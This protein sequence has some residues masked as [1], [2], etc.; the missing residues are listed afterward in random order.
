[1]NQ[2]ATNSERDDGAQRALRRFRRLQ[3]LQLI[4]LT[5]VA[6]LVVAA[7]AVSGRSIIAANVD[8]RE[9]L[10][11]Q[12][13][14]VAQ[15]DNLRGVENAFWRH[16]AS[17][18]PGIPLSI[19]SAMATARDEAKAL[20]ALERDAG[21][22]PGEAAAQAM[23]DGI[24]RSGSLI[25]DYPVYG[26]AVERKLLAQATALMGNVTSITEAW[27]AIHDEQVAKTAVHENDATRALLVRVAL[28]IS[29]LGLVTLFT[30]ILTSRARVGVLD[31]L[32]SSTREQAA[33]RR[34]ATVVASEPASSAVF[35]ALARE[36]AILLGTDLGRVMRFDEA[37]AAVAGVWTRASQGSVFTAHLPE[38]WSISHGLAGRV[39]ASQ[40]CARVEWAQL[41]DPVARTFAAGGFVESI[42][43]P[44]WV[45]S[46]LWGLV[47]VDTTTPGILGAGTEDRLAQFAYLAGLAIA[48]TEARERLSAQAATDPLT[49]LANHGAFHQRLE[50]EV[51]RAQRNGRELSLVLIDLDHFKDINDT[52]G[53]QVGDRVLADI[54][55]ALSPLVREGELLARVGGEELAWL[56]PES[57]HLGAHAAAERARAA[58]S[59]ARP[60]DLD[61]VTASAGVCSLDRAGSSRE[62]YRLADAALFW[63]KSQGRDCAI[64]YEQDAVDDIPHH[65]R[66][67]QMERART[68]GAL[69][70]LARAVDA[71]DPATQRHSE[72]VATMTYD[73]AIE[74]GWSVERAGSLREAALVHDV[75][76][77]GVPDA[78]L[79]K[80]GR[81]DPAEY[82]QIQAHSALGAQIVS[83]VLTP[84]QVGWV[85]HHHERFDAGG[86]PDRL[87]GLDIPEGA[88]IMAVA[89]SWDA[90]TGQRNYRDALRADEALL[91]CQTA[92]G[93]QFDSGV[94]VS[95][96]RL[97]ARGVLGGRPTHPALEAASSQHVRA[98]N[99]RDERFSDGAA[100]GS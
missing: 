42:A 48:N 21:N 37:E 17:G 68:L 54:A 90:M 7:V 35:D 12:A 91:E 47:A 73:L 32:E 94:I 74:H 87:S 49:G 69:R 41:D 63:A 3:S 64:T 97:Y 2:D 50:A 45:D 82:A 58:I 70:A 25:A 44:I 61:T 55:R 22:T 43:A 84:E 26:A 99:S 89:D 8:Q 62:L 14:V 95:L 67:A 24:E 66:T 33:L 98:L 46:I 16:R 72:R 60:G 53:H 10:S 83:E 23:L 85:R 28:L 52:F 40:A 29:L 81:L 18:K 75:G 93:T 20:L 4:I 78:V 34:V 9:Q 31:H 39:L 1:V 27:V 92:S 79:L 86:Y 36:V 38:T 80:P 19:R 51:A 96:E 11:L 5:L 76:K 100:D 13:R 56:L 57:E 71:R 77:I 30:W 65:E 88:R 15:R 59:A 6:G